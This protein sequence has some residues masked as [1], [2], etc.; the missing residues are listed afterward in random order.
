MVLP[1][2]LP[3]LVHRKCTAMKH[4]GGWGNAGIGDSDYVL[5]RNSPL[6]KIALIFD[7]ESLI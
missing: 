3:Y 1:L 2:I 7:R 6:E 5:D 4:G